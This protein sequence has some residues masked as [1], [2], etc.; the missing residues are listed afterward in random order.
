M[1]FVNVLLITANYCK[2]RN[3]LTFQDKVK[4][5]ISEIIY[6]NS[7]CPVLDQCI[8]RKMNILILFT[9]AN[10]KLK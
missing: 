5:S 8:I 7:W 10:R 9:L 6:L 1:H 3:L 2:S 4:L